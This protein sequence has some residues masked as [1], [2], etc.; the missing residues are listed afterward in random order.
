MCEFC[1]QH[2]EGKKWYLQAKNYSE[3]MLSDIKRQKFLKEFLSAPDKLAEA[4]QKMEDLE[5]APAIVRRVLTWRIT[6]KMKKFH[7]GQVV[8]IEEIEQIFG[9]VTS[10][11]RFAC[12]CR[13]ATIGSEQ[14]Y[15]YGV[16]MGPNGGKMLQLIGEIDA[17]YLNG[18]NAT[19]V[20][21]V[22]R[23]ETLAKFR[24][25]EKEGLCH[26]VWTF[27]T[28][29]IFGICNCDR[30]DCLAMRMAVTHRIPVMFRAEY[31]AS[32][33][34]DLCMGC[35]ECMRVCQFGAIGF[36]AAQE[37]IMIDP[38]RCYGCGVCRAVCVHDAISLKDRTSIPLITKLWQ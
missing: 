17:S 11:S 28:P 33:D 36:S 25:Y 12:I 38:R 24:E 37:K 35:R 8:P 7:Y 21:S 30:S 22:T 14:R 2:G 1:H 27:I 29:F 5:K 23:E 34:L 26:T 10:I 15:C 3:D 20:E 13:K 31:V 32:S 19:G 6:N 18:P 4:I 9:F 16:S